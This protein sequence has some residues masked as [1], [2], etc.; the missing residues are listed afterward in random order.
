MR[1]NL[2]ERIAGWSWLDEASLAAQSESV[3]LRVF[4]E[5]IA[6]LVGTVRKSQLSAIVEAAQATCKSADSQI[7]IAAWQPKLERA[8][9]AFADSQQQ[10]LRVAHAAYVTELQRRRDKAK[11]NNDQTSVDRYQKLLQSFQ[12]QAE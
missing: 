3:K 1:C 5:K 10:Q 7:R 4:E 12:G 11:G 2:S 9:Q 6:R 8:A